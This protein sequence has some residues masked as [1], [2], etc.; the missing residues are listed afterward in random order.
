MLHWAACCGNLPKCWI[1]KNTA[2]THKQI[3]N[4]LICPLSKSRRHH[5]PC[6]PCWQINCR[7]N[8]AELLPLRLW[9]EYFVYKQPTLASKTQL[10]TLAQAI[11]DKC[12]CECDIYW[13]NAQ[14]MLPMITVKC[15]TCL[16]MMH[17]ASSFTG[18]LAHCT[19]SWHLN[20]A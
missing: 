14:L 8:L 5:T 15:C 7:Q 11:S 10:I 3:N 2:H 16:Q 1:D 17:V 9:M 13:L 20:L 6:G 4:V 12:A 19:T 18:Q